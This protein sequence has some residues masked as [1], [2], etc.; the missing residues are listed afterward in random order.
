MASWG[1]KD[2]C[3]KIDSTKQPQPHLSWLSLQSQAASL[4]HIVLIEAVSKVCAIQRAGHQL[5]LSMEPCQHHIEHVGWDICWC[6]R[7][8]KTRVFHQCAHQSV[9][10]ALY[11]SMHLSLYPLTHSI[12]PH[13]RRLFFYVTVCSSVY[14]IQSA[15]TFWG[16][17]CQAQL[18]AFN[19]E[20]EGR[21]RL[22][23]IENL[24]NVSPLILKTTPWLRIIIFI[25]LGRNQDTS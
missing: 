8:W 18:Y 11:L 2:A 14:S 22:M 5:H 19:N 4:H 12:F 6:G 13:F 10:L 21:M 16:P 1:C 20:L 3:A 7:L 15:N 17:M 23:L 9:W 24:V 25:F